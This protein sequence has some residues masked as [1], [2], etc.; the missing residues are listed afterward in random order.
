MVSIGVV[1]TLECMVT[2]YLLLYKLFIS[3]LVL[4]MF[5]CPNYD[6]LIHVKIPG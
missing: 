2:T 5:H 6:A 1:V 3:F 4:Y